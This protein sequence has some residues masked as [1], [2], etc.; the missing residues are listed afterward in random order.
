MHAE[1]SIGDTNGV[2]HLIVAVVGI[3]AYSMCTV[4]LTHARS[5]APHPLLLVTPRASVALSVL[6]PF[7]FVAM[8][9]MLN[10]LSQDFAPF[11]ADLHRGTVPAASEGL[12]SL[13]SPTRALQH[14]DH[15]RDLDIQPFSV[16]EHGRRLKEEP[17]PWW[18]SH[19]PWRVALA[20]CKRVWVVAARPRTLLLVH[21]IALSLC[22]V[23]IRVVL[24]L[25]LLRRHVRLLVHHSTAID[26]LWETSRPSRRWMLRRRWWWLPIRIHL[27]PGQRCGHWRR[28]GRIL[29]A[30]CSL[31]R[32]NHCRRRISDCWRDTG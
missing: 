30:T 9:R 2:H 26:R 4:H 19:L 16:V 1:Q 18:A 24:L 22:I 28:T 29:A 8:I 3:A 12:G 6:A 27:L 14:G 15:G 7:H 5:S 23:G 20:Y 11:L 31:I 13:A 32:P 25:L 21:A 10:G 17:R